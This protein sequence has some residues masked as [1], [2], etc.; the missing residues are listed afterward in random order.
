MRNVNNAVVKMGPNE[1]AKKESNVECHKSM[2][3]WKSS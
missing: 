3:R 2:K 1:D